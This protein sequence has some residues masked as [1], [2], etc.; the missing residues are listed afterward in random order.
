MYVRGLV[1]HLFDENF[2]IIEPPV[3]L[4]HTVGKFIAISVQFVV[5]VR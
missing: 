4:V 3:G 5:Q 1:H 2:E